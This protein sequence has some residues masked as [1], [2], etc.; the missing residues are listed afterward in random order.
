MSSITDHLIGIA[1]IITE[2]IAEVKPRL[3]VDF[4]DIIADLVAFEKL[5]P[6]DVDMIR[7]A[8]FMFEDD[9]R[10]C[11]ITLLID[12]CEEVAQEYLAISE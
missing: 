10:T 6:A 7:N 3:Y 11:Q 9:L 5:S 2:A 12:A 1:Q 4:Y 8:S